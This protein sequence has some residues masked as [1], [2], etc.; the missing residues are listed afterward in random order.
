[1]QSGDVVGGIEFAA[2]DGTDLASL[3]A[4]IRAEIDGTPGAND[5]PGRL[6]F[7]TTA[8]GAA[9]TTEHMRLTAAGQLLMHTGTALEA[10]LGGTAVTPTF[11]RH[12]TGASESSQLSARWVNTN[13]APF[14]Q[15]GKSRG[16]VGVFTVVAADDS[17]GRFSWA[18]ADGTNFAEA[19]RIEALVDGTPGANDMPGR[20]VFS[21][22]ADGSQTPTERL[23]ISS[24]GAWGLAGANYGAAGEVL[25]SNGSAAAPTWQAAGGG[26]GA[27]PTASVGL[28]AV[29]GVAA[30]FMRSDG[31]PALSQAIAPTWSGQ[32]IWSLS[33]R[34][35]NGSAATP[36]FNFSNDTDCGMYRV[37]TNEIAWATAGTQRLVLTSD[38]RFYGTALHNNAG[39][40]TGTAN[41]Y[42]ASGTYTPTLTDGTNVAGSSAFSTH[43]MR[44]GNVVTV[45]GQVQIDPTAAGN[46]VLNMSLPIASD[47]TTSSEL[48]GTAADTADEVVGIIGNS[49]TNTAQFQYAAVDGSLRNFAFTFTYVVL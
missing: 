9:D 44:V 10:V 6:V 35:P 46:T 25:T 3:V 23:R 33:L 30:T 13:D 34:G 1:V 4:S 11:Q 38:G 17:L 48:G 41:Q 12:G 42:L 2:A 19:V 14:F 22:S 36:A 18:G 40:V 16:G 8:D 20:L 26:S 49:S 24:A 31:A 43:W 28:A 39:A 45:A 37:T 32:H 15:F 21:T 7:R 27:N 29:N 5:T 47:L